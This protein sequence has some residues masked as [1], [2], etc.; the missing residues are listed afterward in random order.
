MTPLA[1]LL[2]ALPK[3]VDAEQARKRLDDVA[4]QSPDIA[5]LVAN[6]DELT[7]FFEGVFDGS[8]YL[9]SLAERDAAALADMLAGDPDEVAA[10]ILRRMAEAAQPGG[11]RDEVMAEL[12]RGKRQ[13]ALLAGICDLGGVWVGA[14][15]TGFLSDMFDT[16]I[17]TVIRHL[18][19]DAASK[20]RFQPHDA[21]DPEVKSGLIVWAMGKLG[22][23]E[24]NYSSD[25]DLI[26]FYDPEI[27]PLNEGVEPAP[28]FTKLTQQ[29]A[30]MLQDRTADGYVARTDLRLRP[31]PGST[32]VAIALEAALIY[33]ETVGQNW[34]RAAMIKARSCAGDKAA[35]DALHVE[36]APFIW[37]KYLDYAAISDIHAMKRQIHAHR[38]HGDIAIEGHN[39]KLGRGG[40]REI[41]FFAQTQQLVAGGRNP[42]LRCR[43]TQRALNEL[44]EAKWISPEARDEMIEAYWFLRG[45]EHRLQ[46]VNDEQTHV[47]P[48]DREGMEVF[49][50]FCGYDSRDALAIDL[51]K[52]FE[53]VEQ[54][55]A[56]LFEDAPSLSSTS[57]N[58]VFVGEDDDPE[59]LATLAH[60]RFEDPE[61]VS[62]L[63]RGWHRGRY[64]SM[65][66]SRARELMTELVPALLEAFADTYRPDAALIAFDHVLSRLPAG[67]QFMAL[68]RSNPSLL[69]LVAD[70]L[71]TAPR[72]GEAVGRR[73]HVLDA[74]IEPSF[75][76]AVPTTKEQSERLAVALKESWGYEDILNRARIFGQEQIVLIGV[77][78]LSGT[79]PPEQ[80]G[81]AFARLADL[82]VETLSGAAQDEIAASYGHVP[83]GEAAILAMGRLGSCEM[84]ASS[85][86]DLIL[87]YDHD[88]GAL[89]S[90]GKREISPPQ[91]FTRLIQRSVAALTAQTAEGALYEV[92]MRLRP[93]GRSGPLATK[94]SAFEHYQAE[95]AWTWEHMA[96]TRARVM[97]GSKTFRSK[98]ETAIQSIL[99]RKRD[100]AKIAKDVLEM[101]AMIAKEKGDN[102]IWDLK[103]A[104]GGLLDIEF[105]IQFLQLVH[106]HRH[107]EILETSTGLALD[108]LRKHNVLA[109]EDWEVLKAAHRRYHALMQ[110]LRLCLKEQFNPETAGE[111]LLRL[112]ARS[113]SLPDF[114]SLKTELKDSQREV[115]AI[116]QKVVTP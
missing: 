77:R 66:S 92:D 32:S 106:A 67:V 75:F 41:E 116:Y 90:N 23:R 14:R 72:L 24:I 62:R 25:I 31:D 43:E 103:L 53:C 17:S 59:T 30:R 54:H 26:V 69:G 83:G 109:V 2:R 112:L 18:L 55:Y 3:A 91:Y 29:L 98:V 86:L 34:E 82:M 60:M 102:D 27:A 49:A 88:E 113:A 85:D 6:N 36:L 28:F 101:R 42:V 64:Q 78:V 58:L 68:L 52:R 4:E 38:G 95:E 99:C 100:R 21:A 9:W 57:G 5:V 45:I 1:S 16:A 39:V 97:T 37:R 51:L 76:A 70:I 94:L 89:G 93:S 35:G 61:Q 47:L 48:D 63:V 8:P 105:L 115:R 56:R 96:L 11:G 81:A 33:Y 12:R 79:L 40:I 104:K 15:V 19:W 73:P 22:A 46:M 84:T 110:V 71:G 80:A 74:V 65:K 111:G 20:G 87:L 44:T 114:S 50:R 107:P 7:A 108:A 10:A 13:A